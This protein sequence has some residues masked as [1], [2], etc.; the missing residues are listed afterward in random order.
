MCS[1]LGVWPATLVGSEDPA[2]AHAAVQWSIMNDRFSPTENQ[3]L[4]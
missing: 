4:V 1:R 2:V 3:G